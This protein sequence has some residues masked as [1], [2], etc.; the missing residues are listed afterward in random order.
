MPYTTAQEMIQRYG[1]DELAELTDRDGSAGG[2]DQDV[3]DRAIADASAMIDGYL[4]AAGY[5][6]PLDPAPE[7]IRRLCADIS[8]Y[9]LYD[10]AAASDDQPWVVRYREAVRMLDAIRT[11]LIS[12]G[13]AGGGDGAGAP[14]TVSPTRV[15]IREDLQDYG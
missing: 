14:E 10:D 9:L 7:L 6:V 3:L 13:V 1:E 5:A 12:L 11:G 2:I 15:F 8:R 4:R